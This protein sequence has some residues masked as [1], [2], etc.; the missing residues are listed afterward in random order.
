MARRRA[1]SPVG[2]LRTAP[3]GLRV[4]PSLKAELERLSTDANQTLASYI[5]ERLVEHV[6]STR[7]KEG[8][9]R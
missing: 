6:E 8:K 4:K 9:R 2:E 5:E 1:G 7:K 3:I